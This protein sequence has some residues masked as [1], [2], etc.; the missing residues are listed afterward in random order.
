MHLLKIKKVSLCVF[1]AL[2]MGLANASVTIVKEHDIVNEQVEARFSQVGLSG[3]KAAVIHGYGEDMPLSIAMDIIV[4]KGWYISHNDGAEQLLLNWQGDVSWPYV[5]KNISENNN[6]SVVINWEKKNVD[7]FSHDIQAERLSKTNDMNELLN[8]VNQEQEVIKQAYLAEKERELKEKYALEN[9][10]MEQKIKEKEEAEKAN[11]LYIQKLEEEKSLLAQQREE[12]KEILNNYEKNK[13]KYLMSES[14]KL[15]EVD[16]NSDEK[17]QK[18]IETLDI[19]ALKERYNNRSILPLES[20]FEFFV[21]GGYMQ[22]FD[23]YTPATFIVKSGKS[24]YD[25]MADWANTIGWKLKWDSELDYFIEYDLKFEGNFKEA[26]TSTILLFNKKDKRKLDIE[27]MPM[28]ELIVV[29]EL[30]FK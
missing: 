22:D 30:E 24:L 9:K 12:F 10:M 26:S 18:E 29:T 19:K 7:L 5:L 2:S 1:A 25:N 16:Y 8:V 4:P 17:L 14:N 13:E 6:V 3:E 27:Y 23:Y 15:P 11:A 28:Q 21:K 20:S